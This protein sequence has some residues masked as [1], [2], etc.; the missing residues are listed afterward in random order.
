M[1]R[2]NTSKL[3]KLIQSLKKEEKRYFKL[4]TKKYKQNNDT[5][6]LKVF[7]YLDKTTEVDREKFKKKF[8]QVKGLSGI[9]NYLYK[10]ILKSLRSQGNY[11]D[12]DTVLRDGLTDLDIL[13]K[14]ELLVDAQEK[15]YELLEL[16]KLHDK[17][18]FLPM[19]YEWWFT[20]ENS[21]FH[22]NNVDQ[23]TF[24]QYTTVYAQSIQDLKQYHFYR[25]QLGLSLFLVKD[26]NGRSIFDAINIIQNTLPQ[27]ISGPKEYGLTV[28][29]QELQL[30]R[31]LST[32]LGKPD[33]TYFYA[34]EL[35][36]ILQEQPKELFKA[37]EEYYYRAIISQISYTPNI[38]ALNALI[39]K[40]G[41]TI[42]EGSHPFHSHIRMHLFI[43]QID[44]YLLEENF[45]YFEEFIQENQDNLTFIQKFAPTYSKNLLQYKIAL[46]HYATQNHLEALEIIDNNLLHQEVPPLLKNSSLF[47]KM[48]IYY[49][50][51]EYILLGSFLKNLRRSLRK[52]NALLESEKQLISL[53]SQLIKLPKTQH[54]EAFSKNKAEMLDYLSGVDN[55]KKEFL[56]FFNYIGWI[57][58]QITQQP[59]KKLFFRHT[60]L[61]P[62]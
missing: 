59:F 25:T 3:H 15:L 16:A 57:E 60:A 27:Y 17:I 28:I 11:N 50:E 55:Y 39:E 8:Q 2:V 14:K 18:F 5:V 47:L 32:M 62:F 20:L 24:D 46:Y 6:Y 19:L 21:R 44:L 42:K 31:V 33:H 12:I 22:Y 45:D 37:H 4:F 9:Q 48:I 23:A 36:S 40:I 51:E 56:E 53:I 26:G 41:P 1:N 10:L 49:E 7:D 38:E 43:N 61:I 35:C 13:F 34:Q 30:R 58:S 52:K 54:K 29:L